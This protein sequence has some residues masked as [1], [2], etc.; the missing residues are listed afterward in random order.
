MVR[1]TPGFVIDEGDE[2]VRGFG[3]SSGNVLIDGA[4]PSSKAGMLDALGR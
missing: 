2:A 3:G 1:R 4:R